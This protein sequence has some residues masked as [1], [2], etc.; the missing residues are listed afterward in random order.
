MKQRFTIKLEQFRQARRIHGGLMQLGVALLGIKLSRLTIPSK[1]LRL[2]MYR[3]VFN[4][5]YPPGLDENEADRP[6]WAYR[7][8]NALFTRGIK[9]QC[10]PIPAGTPQ[11]LSPCDGTVQDVGR[12]TR[13]KLLTLKGIEYTLDSLLPHTDARPFEGGHFVVIFLSP[14]DCHRVFC[15]QDGQLHEVI[16][17]PGYRLLVHP[18][19]QSAKYPV[20]SL[21]ERMILRFATGLGPC[22]VVMIA[23]W[24]VGNITLPLAPEFRPRARS[25]AARTWSPPASVMRGDW[26]ATF[27]LGSTVALF[28]PPAATAVPLVSPNEVVKYGQ[29]LFSYPG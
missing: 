1:R 9:P 25:M 8:L 19:F 6:L 5:K 26:V 15:P 7:S 24:G 17:V 11:F 4:K 18:P 29:P 28:M 16:H 14:I 10:R 13:G 23:G 21:N 3:G 12:V 20:Y 2:W 27:E 22:L